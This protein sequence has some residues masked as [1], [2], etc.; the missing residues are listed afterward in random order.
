M[1]EPLV[2]LDT[3]DLDVAD[4][5]SVLRQLAGAGA[6][7]REAAARVAEI[8]EVSADGRPRC[9]VI[10][11]AGADESI[12][13][14]AV[15]VIAS[16]SP[17]P[18]SLHADSGLPAY[19]GPLDLVLGIAVEG[20]DG[21]GLDGIFAGLEEAG[22]RGARLAAV[23][24]GASAVAD[25][26]RAGRGVVFETARG[27]GGFWAGLAPAL[28]VAVTC[29]VT[30]LPL[31][32]LSE[33]AER[34]DQLAVAVRPD[35]E[36]FTN[37]A[38]HLAVDLAES[39]VLIWGST[40]L[41]AVAARRAAAAIRSVAGLPAFG[42]ALS[43]AVVSDLVLLDPVSAASLSPDELAELDDDPLEA[44]FRDRGDAAEPVP[45]VVVLVRDYSDENVA[46]AGFSE[47]AARYARDRGCVVHEL[48][49]T[50]DSRLERLA[51]LVG[52]FD[53]AA[54]YAALARGLDPGRPRASV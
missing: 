24:P 41:A 50:G 2:D 42:S 13:E 6:R 53:A 3:L 11:A 23:C 20:A 31:S 15:A 32:S 9:L 29:G 1:S 7:V 52:L 26:T 44:L 54:V 5:S 8:A 34:L 40:P 38:K 16:A 30:A 19:V 10:L 18:V 37:P 28:A 35:A 48:V 12:G 21:A 45:P 39:L 49:S 47:R 17:I 22:R 51:S 33:V 43:A 14:A 4:P 36:T 25:I 27:S 46:V